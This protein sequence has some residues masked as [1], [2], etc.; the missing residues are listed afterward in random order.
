M[1]AGCTFRA[2]P[3]KA[4]A[5]CSPASYTGERKTKHQSRS[6]VLCPAST[7][8]QVMPFRPG[9]PNAQMPALSRTISPESCTPLVSQVIDNLIDRSADFQ[10]E[11][12]GAP[13][14]R[15]RILARCRMQPNV[16]ALSGID[17]SPIAPPPRAGR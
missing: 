7:L 11:H 10:A 9:L 13:R 2:L 8:L 17:Y 14:S 16:E 6:P 15:H 3:I 4:P 5:Y 12:H 1:D